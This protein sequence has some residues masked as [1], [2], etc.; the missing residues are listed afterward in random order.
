V[1]SD[2]HSLDANNRIGSGG[3]NTPA[4]LPQS[5]QLSPG[6]S[7][8]QN[9][10]GPGGIGTTSG[11]G[12]FAGASPD[13]DPA[14]FRGRLPGSPSDILRQ[15]SGTSSPGAAPTYN[16]PQPYYNPISQVAPP[17]GFQAVPYS[18][19]SF[20]QTPQPTRQP[21]DYRL[22]DVFNTPTPG[23]MPIGQ[24]MG[25]GAVDPTA[26]TTPTFLNNSP[27][28][29]LRD[30]SPGLDGS[31]YSYASADQN[32]LAFSNA[33]SSHLSPEDVTRLRGE[34]SQPA[35]WQ[36]NSGQSNSGS[37]Q[38]NPNSIGAQPFAPTNLATDAAVAVTPISG[39]TDR[40]TNGST[41]QS[42]RQYLPPLPAPAQQSAQYAQLRA[43]LEKYESAKPKKR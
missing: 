7:P 34:L 5:T 19:G 2:G 16:I 36:P 9:I 15:I 17:A 35:P 13:A 30:M 11:I 20:V 38:S 6:F 23:A 37:T 43:Q 18:G 32:G 39:A 27:I 40:S 28:Y 10:F 33:Y 26:S 24:A 29:G 22:G 1:G 8:Q 14:G 21:Q 4:L 3:L 31:S 41:G 42:S 12:S 25:P